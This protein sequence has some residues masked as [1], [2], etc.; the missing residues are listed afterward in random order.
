MRGYSFLLWFFCLRSRVAVQKS[1]F[2]RFCRPW[3]PSPISARDDGERDFAQTAR[4]IVSALL[5]AGSARELVLFRFSEAFDADSIAS[6][7]FA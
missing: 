4:A 6:E 1:N 3:I 5:Q 7:G 2:R